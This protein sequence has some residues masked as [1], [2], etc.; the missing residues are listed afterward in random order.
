MTAVLDALEA[1]VHTISALVSSLSSARNRVEGS[2][3]SKFNAT[4]AN[5]AGS[6]SCRDSETPG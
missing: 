5:L 1:A 2:S 4:Q 6:E 3:P